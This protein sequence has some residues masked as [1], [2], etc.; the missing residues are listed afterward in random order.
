MDWVEDPAA[1][2]TI[3]EL[4]MLEPGDELRFFDHEWRPSVFGCYQV[5]PHTLR[6]GGG[7]VHN[8]LESYTNP[9]L[10][11]THDSRKPG[12]WTLVG[13]RR[14]TKETP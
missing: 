11:S 2:R 6:L 9:E 3:L 4:K 10:R 13:W 12:R 5:N 14:P 1:L 8:V 7:E